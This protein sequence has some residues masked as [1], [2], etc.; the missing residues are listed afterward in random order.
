MSQCEFPRCRDESGCTYITKTLCRRHWALVCQA[1]EEDASKEERFLA[2]LG[3]IRDPELRD[4]ISLG[5]YD[6][7]LKG[8]GR[9]ADGGPFEGEAVEVAKVE[10]SSR[11]GGDYK[12]EHDD[13][14]EAEKEGT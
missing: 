7:R 14:E 10:Q 9:D 12:F 13:D 8:R 6:R 3:L 11:L 5:D 2:R 4:V 1:N